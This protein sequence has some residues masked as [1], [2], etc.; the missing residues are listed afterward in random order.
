MSLT[1]QKVKWLQYDVAVQSWY[2]SFIVNLLSAWSSY[3]WPILRMIV[4]K[5]M[6]GKPNPSTAFKFK[7]STLGF[8]WDS[9]SRSRILGSINPLK[10]AV[11]IKI[12][13]RMV[14]QKTSVDISLSRY[15][16]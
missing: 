16:W 11:Y 1:F 6:P 7:I 3:L 9:V 14:L 15:N 8:F 12:D 13:A 5:F 10:F 4:A 2:M